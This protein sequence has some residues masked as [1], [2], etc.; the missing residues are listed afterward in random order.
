MTQ[1]ADGPDFR[2]LPQR[3]NGWEVFLSSGQ[4]LTISA[5]TDEAGLSEVR[6]A[7][8]RH[9]AGR[10]LGVERVDTTMAEPI[11]WH[12]LRFEL[13]ATTHGLED[14]TPAQVDQL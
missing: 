5:S 4:Q 14:P 11:D 10:T 13:L 8:R 12:G 7:V 3:R 1:S 6:A 2:D 9:L